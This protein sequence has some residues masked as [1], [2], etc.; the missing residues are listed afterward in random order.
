MPSKRVDQVAERPL[1]ELAR[2]QL[3]VVRR[4]LTTKAREAAPGAAMLGGASLFGVLASGTGTGALVLLLARR[5]G[6]S[7]ALA[8]T[9]AYAGAS[10]FLAREGLVRL[11]EAGLL[12]SE[13]ADQDAEPEQAADDALREAAPDDVAQK[14]TRKA[15][16][17]SQRAG[18]PTSR[19]RATSSRPRA[20]RA[21]SGRGRAS[22]RTT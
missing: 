5:P 22:R 8:V 15:K 9:G 18:R 17:A 21:Q 10:A 16:D 13:E 6:A 14:A 19:S 20:S 3:E 12:A 4:G 11:R 7:A 1:E 2:Q